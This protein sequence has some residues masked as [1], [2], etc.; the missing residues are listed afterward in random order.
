MRIIGQATK[1][2]RYKPFLTTC[3]IAIAFLLPN[4]LLINILTGSN[5]GIPKFIIKFQVVDIMALAAK[6]SLPRYDINN[7]A[8]N[9]LDALIIF[10]VANWLAS[11]T[12]SFNLFPIVFVY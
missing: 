10:T 6:A 3:P 7:V 8:I 2:A 11:S 5:S 1:A 9:A 12:K 4:R